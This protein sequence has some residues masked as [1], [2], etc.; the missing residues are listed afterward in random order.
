M[1]TLP[2]LVL[3]IALVLVIFL[4]L[5]F[6]AGLR[7]PLAVLPA[8]EM[9]LSAEQTDVIIQGGRR[10][11]HITLHSAALGD[12]SFA[13]NFPDPLPEQKLPVLFVLG[14]LKYG[15]EN[16]AVLKE[17]GA[18]IIVGYDWPIP[19]H[20][21][22]GLS[23]LWQA[24][25][26]YHQLLGIPAQGV[27]ILHWLAEQPWADASRISVL[28]FSLGALVV[29][30]LQ[31][32]A[33]KSGLNIGWM[34]LAYGGAPLH[35]LF[36]AHPF[37]KPPWLHS[38]TSPL[39]ALLLRPLEPSLHLPFL[40]GRFLILEGQSDDLIPA[41]A[42][43]LMRELTP[44]PKTVIVLEGAHIGLAARMRTQLQ[45]VIRIC[46]VWL[47]ENGAINPVDAAQTAPSARDAQ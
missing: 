19:V 41:T 25:T 4:A 28:G 20:F 24:P 23:L 26:L 27:S 34:V 1:K 21:P 9:N 43:D 33:E 29:P 15:K 7:D 31:N 40:S 35:A 18:N 37:I 2:R 14:G 42:R 5:L 44:Q 36:D 45:Q 39:I 8:P 17:M 6:G 3:L 32:V 16:I 38:L 10:I 12:I 22:Q 11:E 13:V 30:A 46:T 47:S